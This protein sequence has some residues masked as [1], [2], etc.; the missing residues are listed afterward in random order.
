MTSEEFRNKILATSVQLELWICVTFFFVQGYNGGK[1][2]A[3]PKENSTFLSVLGFTNMAHRKKKRRIKIL[4]CSFPFV[5]CHCHLGFAPERIELTDMLYPSVDY[6]L[7]YIPCGTGT[8]SLQ[9]LNWMLG[10]SKGRWQWLNRYIVLEIVRF[11]GTLDVHVSERESVP[12]IRCKGGERFPVCFGPL[13]RAISIIGPVI[14]PDN[15]NEPTFRNIMYMQ[16]TPQNGESVQY[17]ICI[18][19]RCRT[20]HML[21]TYLSQMEK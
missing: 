4:Q 16:F 18:I 11:R 17:N 10:F 19:P 5:V 1:W 9:I 6:Q 12:I 3:I 14:K 2:K 15:T 20:Q 8:V 13:E 21:F 7:L